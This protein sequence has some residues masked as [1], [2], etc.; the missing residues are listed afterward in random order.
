MP[1]GRKVTYSDDGS[2]VV[3]GGVVFR[4]PTFIAQGAIKEDGTYSV[5]TD[6]AN[7]G[8]PPGTYQVTVIGTA[9]TVFGPPRDP[10]SSSDLPSVTMTPKVD[11]KFEDPAT[12]GLTATVGGST[13]KYDIQVD[14]FV[15]K[16]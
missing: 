5:G 16:K 1:F 13:R 2:P 14:R 15:D 7:D 3:Q 10:N 11:P 12:S 6:K 4:T 9:E 8:L